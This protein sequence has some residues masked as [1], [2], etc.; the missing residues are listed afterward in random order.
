M[1]HICEDTSGKVDSSFDESFYSYSDKEVKFTD[2]N[3]S[4]DQKKDINIDNVSEGIG[5][6]Q[7][8]VEENDKL[9][10]TSDSAVPEKMCRSCIEETIL[11]FFDSKASP[12]AAEKL[13][14]V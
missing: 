1:R 5:C 8:E 2:C 9:E 7:S 6:L 4:F 13:V 11:N 10:D 12:T 14:N 3:Y